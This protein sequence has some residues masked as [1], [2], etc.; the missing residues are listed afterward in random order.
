MQLLHIACKAEENIHHFATIR[1]LLDVGA[2][3]NSVDKDGNA[4]LHLVARLPQELMDPA[5]SLLLESGA[6]LDRINNS[7]KTASDIWIEC[8][9]KD[10][11]DGARWKARPDWCSATRSLSCLSARMI[12][13]NKVPY[14]DG[15][16][17]V[18]LIPFVDMH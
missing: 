15:G 11:N 2:D 12:R 6:Y 7:G 8:N 4:P 10:E 16:L 13:L 14:S 17:P 1:L 5:V 3:P 18:T 9:E